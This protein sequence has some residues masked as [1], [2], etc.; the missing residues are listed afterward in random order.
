[1]GKKKSNASG[2]APGPSAVVYKGPIRTKEQ[3]TPND[4]I[5]VRLSNT[6]PQTGS[7]VGLQFAVSNSNVISSGDWS[8]YVGAYD[9]HRVLG[10]EVDWMP[11]AGAGSTQYVQSTGFRISTHAPTNPTPFTSLQTMVQYAD[12]QEF[13]TGKSSK[14]MWKMA[15]T[16]EAQ[17]VPTSGTPGAQ[18]FICVFAPYATS[19]T[20][21]GVASVTW[22]VQF[23]GRS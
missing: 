5:T 16:E 1:M 15:S 22:V 23:R 9:E 8:N 13:N 3:G 6:Y 4:L 19:T 7:S 21:Y 20:V 11:N 12:W 18:G 14:T 2:A 17:F 10:F